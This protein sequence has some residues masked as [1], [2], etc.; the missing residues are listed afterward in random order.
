M[1]E[2]IGRF[3]DELR[4]IMMYAYEMDT[5]DEKNFRKQLKKPEEENE[6]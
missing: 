1:R 3:L 2:K 6:E 4:R 5:Y